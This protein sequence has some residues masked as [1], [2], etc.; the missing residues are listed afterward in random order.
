MRIFCQGSVS[1]VIQIVQI[2]E[3]LICVLNV[4]LDF[5]FLMVNVIKF[6]LK[7]HMEL[8]KFKEL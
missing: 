7:G 5:I 3:E 1:L 6:A 2:V 4:F 8:L